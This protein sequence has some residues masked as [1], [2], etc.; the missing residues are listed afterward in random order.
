[1]ALAVKRDARMGVA[2]YRRWV[3]LR[4]DAERR[5][6]LAG[7]PVL[8]APSRAR[9]QAA[10]AN[11]IR[12]RGDLADRKGCRARPGLAIPSAAMDDVAPIP[13]GVVR[14]GPPLADG[15]AEDPRRV[16]E[17]RAPST[18][19]FGR[20]RE[21]DRYRTVP[22]L[23][24]PLMVYADEPRVEVWRREAEDRTVRAPGPDGTVVLAER[25]GAIP[26][27]DISR[28]LAV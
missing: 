7:A 28:G 20:G 1:M 4:P 3:A 16:A 12:R 13:D 11:L 22:G 14:C 23:G 5:D 19:G 21:F 2:E 25:D 9:L 10:V 6:L 15:H 26:G 18:L 24:I 8:R 17:V 27:R